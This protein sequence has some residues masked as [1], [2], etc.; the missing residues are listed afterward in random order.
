[1]QPMRESK[2]LRIRAAGTVARAFAPMVA[3]VSGLVWLMAGSADPSQA[4]GQD[5]KTDAG[6]LDYYLIDTPKFPVKAEEFTAVP[7]RNAKPRLSDYRGRYILLNFWATWCGPCKLEMPD[8]DA[9]YRD[10][11]KKNLVVLAVSMEEEADKVRKFIAG[12]SYSFPVL[13]D[14]DGIVSQL[15]GVDSIPLTYL[16]STEGWIVGRALGPREWNDPPFKAFLL[17][18]MRGR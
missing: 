1:M 3:I 7:I 14:P 9:L 16:I 15:Y 17:R 11:G 13:A 8:L 18:Q 10:L 6:V 4:M 5:L 12:T 2:W